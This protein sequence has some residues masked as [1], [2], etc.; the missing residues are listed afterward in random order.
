MDNP[1]VFIFGIILDEPK[2]IWTKPVLEN[3]NLKVP[4][5]FHCNVQTNSNEIDGTPRVISTEINYDLHEWGDKIVHQNSMVQL[6]V[7]QKMTSNISPDGVRYK[8]NIVKRR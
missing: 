4:A 8:C 5:G 2:L 7:K 1:E 6:S 3:N